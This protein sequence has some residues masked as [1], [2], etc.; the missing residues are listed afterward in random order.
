MRRV[1]GGIAI[2][3]VLLVAISMIWIFGGQRLSLFLDRFGTMEMASAPIELISYEGSGTSGNLLIKNIHLSLSVENPKNR[4]STS[5]RQKMSNLHYHSVERFSPSDRCDR[6]QR[7][8]P[9]NRQ[10]VTT[11]PSQLGIAP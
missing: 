9:P 6:E 1:L 7:L 11:P 8:L 10:Q 2:I 4:S 5:A 3:V